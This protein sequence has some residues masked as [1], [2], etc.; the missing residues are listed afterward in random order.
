MSA[1]LMDDAFSTTIFW[2]R[3]SCM[4][5]MVCTYGLSERALDILVG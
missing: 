2:R 5:Q 1:H 4:E 3:W